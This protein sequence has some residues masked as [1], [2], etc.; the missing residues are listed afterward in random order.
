MGRPHRIEHASAVHHVVSRSNA[1]E[2]IF[3]HDRDASVFFAT[4]ARAIVD[5]GWRCDAYCLMPTHYHLLLQTPRPTLSTG[6]HWLNA[7]YA[8][9]FNAASGRRGHVFQKRFHSELV[10]DDVHLAE[11]LRYIALNPVRA[12][13]VDGPGDWAW[14]SYRATAGLEGGPAWL[15]WKPS[16]RLFASE[17]G[18][19]R[20]AY[21]RFVREGRQTPRSRETQ[22]E[23]ARRL[24][25]S[26][27][28]VSRMLRKQRE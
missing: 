7:S 20:S 16:L 4:L 11:A 22:V 19:A 18:E 28:T 10:S 14:S 23:M 26:Q 13:L 1:G 25:V 21:Q 2:E 27:A 8:R 9:L 12:G 5:H 17:T 3:R 24:G 6:M 15:S